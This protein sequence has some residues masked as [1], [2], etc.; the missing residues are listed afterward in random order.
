M[1]QALGLHS[2]AVAEHV[3]QLRLHKL[4]PRGFC[5][6]PPL[7][8]LLL[9]IILAVWARITAF[10]GSSIGERW[11]STECRCSGLWRGE[12]S[13]RG[14][15]D[16]NFESINARLW[17]GGGCGG[18]SWRGLLGR[19]FELISSDARRWRGLN[20]WGGL[21]CRKSKCS[22]Q[23]RRLLRGSSVRKPS[24]ARCR[25]RCSSAC[26]CDCCRCSV[27]L[28]TVSLALGFRSRC[29]LFL[30]PPLLA[31]RSN[32]RC[33]LLDRCGRRAFLVDEG[34]IK[35]KRIRV[36]VDS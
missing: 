13:W 5:S 28:I 2:Q 29:L 22:W 1:K 12:N 23:G 4:A 15:L 8:L 11:L 30:L 10:L 24:N 34:S 19:N 21:L 17:R 27:L 3:N 32:Q 7:R 33:R 6:E 20:S 31:V 18:N 9:A 35:P 14:L 36:A 25:C 26:V 16:M